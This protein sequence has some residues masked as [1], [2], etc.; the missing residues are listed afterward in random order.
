MRRSP[1]SL[2]LSTAVAAALALGLT[3][4]GGST[5]GKSGSGGTGAPAKNINTQPGNDINPQPREKIADGGTLRW[6]EAAISDQLN[7]NE[8]DGTDGSTSDIMAA[9]LEEPFYA[10]AKGVPHNNVNLVA[11]YTVT[12]SPQQV[13][14]LEIGR[15]HV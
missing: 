4:C 5:S 3:A 1:R 9:V 12:Q 7:Y 8:V 13:V 14:T 2:V 6:P 11:S 15:A 10:D